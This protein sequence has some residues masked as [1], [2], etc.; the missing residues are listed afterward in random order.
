[1]TDFKARVIAIV[2]GKGG[3]GKTTTTANIGAALAY[4][5]KED[6]I[7][8]DANTTSSGLGIQLGQYDY[9]ISLN[10]VLKGNA[11]ISQAMYAHPSGAR[12]IPATT[13]LEDLDT[14]PQE[15][16][17]TVKELEDYADYI[18]LDCA[19]TLGEE[20]TAGIEA[21]KEIILVTNTDWPSLLEAKRT[22]EYC[23][24][25]KKEMLGVILTKTK[26]ENTYFL[27]KV[28]ETLKT[29][30]L[31]TVRDDKKVTESIKNRAPV[32]HSHP[33]SKAA[34]DYVKIIEKITGDKYYGKRNIIGNMLAAVGLK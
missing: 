29:K 11:N 34:K 19:P 7:I 20:S 16:K 18:L 8:I 3:V 6:V 13:H 10:D 33:Y 22:I 14:R 28:E 15:L 26:D 27:Q 1:M 2:S 23:R 25:E 31:G 17:K 32:I 30:I 5:Y 12:I 4:N 21:A 24:A 9:E